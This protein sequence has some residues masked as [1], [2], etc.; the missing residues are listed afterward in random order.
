MNS[1]SRTN[2]TN[3]CYSGTKSNKTGNYTRKTFLTSM[4]KNFKNPCSVYIK[5]LK[6]KSCKKLIKMN[7]REVKNQ[8]NAKLKNKTYKLK[9]SMGEKLNNQ[10]NKCIRCKYKNNKECN[11]N[12]YISFSGA[13]I[14]KCE[15]LHTI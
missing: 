2:S 14:G 12:N 6:C 9:N 13:S 10:T 11:L 1:M 3:I 7:D 5:S 4:N 8:V 15:T